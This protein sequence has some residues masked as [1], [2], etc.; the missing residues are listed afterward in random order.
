VKTFY[1]AGFMA[2][3]DKGDIVDAFVD[4]IGTMADTHESV[5]EIR[6]SLADDGDSNTYRVLKITV[7]E[8]G[9]VTQ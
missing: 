7:E 1:I 2:P 6:H 4:D 8:V 3:T 5:E 9:T